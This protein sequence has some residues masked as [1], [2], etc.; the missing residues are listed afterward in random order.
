MSAFWVPVYVSIEVNSPAEAVRAKKII[1]S[2]LTNPMVS[3]MLQAQGVPFTAIQVADP[4]PK[5]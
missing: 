4:T 3:G 5:K 2:L 1:E